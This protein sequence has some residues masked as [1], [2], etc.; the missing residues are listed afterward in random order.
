MKNGDADVLAKQWS[1]ASPQADDR[2]WCNGLS[3]STKCEN[4][5]VQQITF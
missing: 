1:A 3:W 4:T 2:N 5:L